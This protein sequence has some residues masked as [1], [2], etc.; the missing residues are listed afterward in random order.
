[1]NF[2][3][4]IVLHRSVQ[5]V[6]WCIIFA[7]CATSPLGRKQFIIVPDQQME[8]MGAQ[9]FD[10]MKGK[11]RIDSDPA[12][13]EFIQCVMKRLTP[14][15]E[16]K[17]SVSSWD[18]V[19]FL[20]DTA[21]AFALPG[22]RVGVFTG[23]LKVAKNDAQLAAVLGHEIGHVIARHGAER[24]SQ[25]AGTQMGLAAL[26]AITHQNPHRDTLMGL[27]GLGAQYGILLPFNRTQESEADYIGLDLMAEAGFDPEQSVELWRNMIVASGGK[28]PPQWLST[29]PA[30]ENR[31]IALQRRMPQALKLYREAQMNSERVSCPHP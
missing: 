8:T 7:A 5:V 14:V 26:G 6:A 25:Q 13:R 28:A 16:K 11:E 3:R 4:R 27:L 18:V 2:F 23:L 22:G 17:M 9:A 29:H 24:V 31:I 15:S 10:E 20:N 19:V 1:M 30:S 21:N 12:V